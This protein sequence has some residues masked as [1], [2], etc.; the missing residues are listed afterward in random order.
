[1]MKRVRICVAIDK[2]GVYG[3]GTEGQGFTAKSQALEDL[4]GNMGDG[5]NYRLVYIVAD[6]PMPEPV[7]VQGEV[8]SG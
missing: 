4:N 5:D 3:A 1:M 7:T 2:N 8:V 6:V